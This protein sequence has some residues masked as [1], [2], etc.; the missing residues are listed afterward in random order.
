M[1]LKCWTSPDKLKMVQLLQLLTREP[2]LR[3]TAFQEQKGTKC[4]TL[5]WTIVCLQGRSSPVGR[6]E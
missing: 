5:G 1:P 2:S 6:T 4:S 3:T